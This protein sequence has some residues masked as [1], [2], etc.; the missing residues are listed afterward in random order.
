V[1]QEEASQ[2]IYQFHILLLKISPAIWRRVL[3]SSGQSLADFHDTL[4]IVMGWDDSHLHRFLIHG[5]AYGI[6]RD[7]V[8][9]F[10]MTPSRSGSG[11]C[12]SGSK[13]VFCMNMIFTPAG[14]TRFA[15]S[16]RSPLIPLKPTRCALVERVRLPRTGA[17]TR[18]PISNNS[19]IFPSGILVVVFSKLLRMKKRGWV[20]TRRK[21][22]PC[23][24]GCKRRPLIVRQRIAVSPFS[25]QVRSVGER[26]RK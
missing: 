17:M 11:I 8:S 19:S 6:A 10:V 20:I 18:L 1:A 25:P 23:S 26:R 24:T 21:R 5:R 2:A 16:E 14:N 7:G 9:G 15:W 4:Q 22:L 12:I 3:V 13:S